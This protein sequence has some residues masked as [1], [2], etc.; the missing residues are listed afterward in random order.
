MGGPCWAMAHAFRASRMCAARPSRT[1]WSGRRGRSPLR[2]WRAGPPRRRRRSDFLDGGLGSDR[3]VGGFGNDIFIVDRWATSSRAGGRRQRPGLGER[4]LRSDRRC[5]CRSAGD[6][7]QRGHGKYQPDRQRAGA[8]GGRQQWHEHPRWRRRPRR[9]G[10]PRRQRHL[11]RR[12]R[13]HGDR[14]SRRRQRPG[15]GES[16]TTCL[17]PACASSF[18][19]RPPMPAPATST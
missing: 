2:Q 4:Q 5:A 10:R 15:A 9:P 14:G 1:S 12:R 17:P 13:R 18:C 19:R 11:H 8:G 7:Q 16:R 6:D 3:M